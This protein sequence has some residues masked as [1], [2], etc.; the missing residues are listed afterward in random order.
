MECSGCSLGYLLLATHLFTAAMIER[1]FPA[2]FTNYY[3]HIVA[4]ANYLLRLRYEQLPQQFRRLIYSAI[5]YGAFSRDH[6]SM[7]LFHALNKPFMALHCGLHI[8][9]N[10]QP[11]AHFV[12]L[13]YPST[14]LYIWE[15]LYLLLAQQIIIATTIAVIIP[16]YTLHLLYINA[17][18]YLEFLRYIRRTFG[19]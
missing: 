8:L 3:R 17:V 7:R 14:L 11:F 10:I 16:A 18:L 12:A 2:L 15:R 13:L 4:I 19:I 9:H 1:T 5:Y 6:Q